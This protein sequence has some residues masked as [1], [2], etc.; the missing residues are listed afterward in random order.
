MTTV[1]Q[2]LSSKT[3][4]TFHTIEASARVFDAIKLMAYKQ[5]GALVVMSRS[6]SPAS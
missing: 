4:Q 5:I 6:T 3:D 1:A 2:L